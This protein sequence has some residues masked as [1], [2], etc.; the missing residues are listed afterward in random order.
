M[1][2]FFICIREVNAAKSQ[3]FDRKR[4]AIT[5]HISLTFNRFDFEG[6]ILPHR[7]PPSKISKGTNQIIQHKLNTF[8]SFS[9]DKMD[10]QHHYTI[11]MT[12]YCLH[13]ADYLACIAKEQRSNVAVWVNVAKS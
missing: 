10:R 9:E 13:S 8:I 3:V 11:N 12:S 6:Q 1:N 2:A 7:L 4:Q 5:F